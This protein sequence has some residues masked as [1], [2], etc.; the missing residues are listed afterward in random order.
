MAKHL[1]G[2]LALS[3]IS[4]LVSTYRV[5]DVK[6]PRLCRVADRRELHAPG[7]DRSCLHVELEIPETM[8]YVPCG[9]ELL[10]IYA[11]A[12]LTP[13]RNMCSYEAGD[14][15][16]IFAPN[17]TRLVEQAAKLLNVNLDSVVSVIPVAGG[18]PVI[19]PCTVRR[20]LAHFIELSSVPRKTFMIVRTI[21]PLLPTNITN[22]DREHSHATF[23][24]SL[25][26]PHVLFLLQGVLQYTTDPDE[27]AKLERLLADDVRRCLHSFA[28]SSFRR[29]PNSSR[30]ADD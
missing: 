23:G 27:R 19:G 20:V 25:S 1:A 9:G 4:V 7:S 28:H 3:L 13:S 16:G 6:N 26:L 22:S 5:V 18:R 11:H 29:V 12:R 30:G 2:R 8:M 10:Y 24:A 17:S 21:S 15:I 14:H